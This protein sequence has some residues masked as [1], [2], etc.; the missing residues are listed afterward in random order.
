MIIKEKLAVLPM[1]YCINLIKIR[2]RQYCI[3]AS[4]DRDG[5]MLLID[6]QTKNVQKVAGLAGGVMS[7]LPIPEREGEFLAIQR[8]YPVFDSKEAEIVHCR[9]ERLVGEVLPASVRTVAKLPYVHRIALTGSPGARKLV[10]ATLCQSKEYTDDWSQPGAVYEYCLNENLEVLDRKLLLEGIHKN[11]GMFQYQK[12]NGT[13]VLVSGTEGAWAIDAQGGTRKLCGEPVS[14][15]CMFD[16]D[17]DDRDEMICITPFHGDTL[18][19]LKKS[20]DGWDTLTEEKLDFG[21]AVWCGL[22][23]GTPVILAC[24][25]GGERNTVLYRPFWNGGRLNMDS[26]HV[27][28]DVGASNILVQ[29]QGDAVVLYAANHGRNETA[30]YTIQL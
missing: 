10:A 4:E 16:V 27:D 13:Y 18:K 22:C 3:T 19:V 26:I 6:T 5:E 28:L 24:S 9:L 25:R 1:G 2:G 29:Q 23:G 8:F 20:G 12:A 14:D 7:V 15:L 21:H 17:G 30:R 11:H